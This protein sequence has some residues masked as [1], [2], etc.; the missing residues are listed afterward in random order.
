MIKLSEFIKEIQEIANKKCPAL[1]IN[2]CMERGQLVVVGLINL[3][4]SIAI[5]LMEWD[6]AINMGTKSELVKERL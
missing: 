6:E 2:V 4:D 5:D 1:H 3:G